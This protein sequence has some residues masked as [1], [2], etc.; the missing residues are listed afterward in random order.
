MFLFKILTKRPGM[1]QWS[2]VSSISASLLT[3]F[4]IG[5]FFS[6][7]FGGT[8]FFGAGAVA[9]E[10]EVI[11][12]INDETMRRI[13]ILL[14]FVH[15][16]HG[17]VRVVRKVKADASKATAVVRVGR[18]S[19]RVGWG[20]VVRWKEWNSLLWFFF[21]LHLFRL[22]FLKDTRIEKPN[23]KF[24]IQT[25]KHGIQW[26][27]FG[28]RSRSEF[29]FDLLVWVLF[30]FCRFLDLRNEN[31]EEYDETYHFLSLNSHLAGVFLHLL[32][33]DLLVIFVRNLHALLQVRNETV[34][35]FNH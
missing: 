27:L 3:D 18:G 32:Q 1:I 34:S 17:I 16:W 33:S 11:L 31:E 8:A 15:L 9:V 22:H 13:S 35:R 12:E 4:A 30:Q 10:K 23:C 7:A 5:S 28:Y 21:F 26:F 14:S 25:N 19:V 6:S 2:F 20:G 29:K 24:R